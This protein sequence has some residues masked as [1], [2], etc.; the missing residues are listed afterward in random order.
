MSKL[1]EVFS[2]YFIVHNQQREKKEDL[3]I[4]FQDVMHCIKFYG[5]LQDSEVV[6]NF[7][8]YYNMDSRIKSVSDTLNLANGV[9]FP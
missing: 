9:K 4:T 5:I 1:Y 2:N 7:F 6:A 8:D 3:V